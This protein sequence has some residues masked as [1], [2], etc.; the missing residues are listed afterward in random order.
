M[1]AWWTGFFK[2]VSELKNKGKNLGN[3]LQFREVKEKMK[4][5]LEFKEEKR[6]EKV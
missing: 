2:Q 1:A 6:R 3:A 5:G 4:I